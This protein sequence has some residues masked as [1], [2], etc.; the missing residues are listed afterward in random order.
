MRSKEEEPDGEETSEVAFEKLS[1]R[2]IYLRE[3]DQFCQRLQVFRMITCTGF[4]LSWS[5]LFMVLLLLSQVVWL[6]SC[7]PT[8]LIR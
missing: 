6:I 3:S 8:N 5:T 4:H 1:T 7:H 2:S